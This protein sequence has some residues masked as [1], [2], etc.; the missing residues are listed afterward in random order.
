MGAGEKTLA[1][2]RWGVTFGR[3]MNRESES[4]L[5]GF[6]VEQHGRF[7][8]EA[9]GRFSMV[10]RA[11]LAAVA[12]YLAGVAWYGHAAE[13]AEVAA[14]LSP[15][16]FAELV[17]ATDFDASRFGGMLKTHLRQ[18]GQLTGV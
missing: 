13:L 17:R 14:E 4:C 5:V 16:G 7:D 12:R 2:G 8:A 15:L 6:C 9:W 3:V 1:R 10:S 18:A 11:E